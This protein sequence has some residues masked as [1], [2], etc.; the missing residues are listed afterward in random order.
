LLVQYTPQIYTTAESSD[1]TFKY[2][3]TK[4]MHCVIE[5]QHRPITAMLR[6]RARNF[7]FVCTLLS[8]LRFH[9][10]NCYSYHF[11]VN[12]DVCVLKIL[13]LLIR[14]IL[15]LIKVTRVFFCFFL[16]V[17]DTAWTS[18]SGLTKCCTG[19]ARGQ[20]LALS[21]SYLL[22]IKVTKC[23]DD[24]GRAIHKYSYVIGSQ[25]LRFQLC[26]FYSYHF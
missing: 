7:N 4:G 12:K 5:I 8:L 1:L 21:K 25:L 3:R 23:L 18:W 13:L 11:L 26:N 24:S 9:L 22:E 10:C 16:C 6:R 19:I 14:A 2:R 20:Y 15:L 17:H